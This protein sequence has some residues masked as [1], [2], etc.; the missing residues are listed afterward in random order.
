M[1]WSFDLSQIIFYFLAIF[2]SLLHFHLGNFNLKSR[3]YKQ[4]VEKREVLYTIQKCII[5]NPDDKY[6][7]R[8]KVDSNFGPDHVLLIF[9]IIIQHDVYLEIRT[10]SFI[11]PRRPTSY[12]L[13]ISK[14]II[15]SRWS[16]PIFWKKSIPIGDF[17]KSSSY[18][19]LFMRLLFWK[20]CGL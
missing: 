1:L 15:E 14:V 20:W 16:S 13:I 5:F 11:P 10:V 12:T 6:L 17:L 4:S 3:Q 9:N 8:P 7:A 2:L 19:S 18:S